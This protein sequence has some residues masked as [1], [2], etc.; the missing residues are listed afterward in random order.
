MLKA[1]FDFLE[2]WDGKVTY[3]I[4]VVDDGSTDG[5]SDLIR[6]VMKQRMAGEIKLVQ[7]G[8]NQGK[9]ASVRTGVQL[10]RGSCVLMVSNF[11]IS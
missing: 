11:S 7:V 2:S 10:A 3:E 9:G 1:T 5:T 6:N 4:I 8:R